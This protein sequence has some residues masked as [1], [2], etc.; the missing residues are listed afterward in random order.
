MV[1]TAGLAFLLVF[2]C[3]PPAYPAGGGA[4]SLPTLQNSSASTA[5]LTGRP[6]AT[7]PEM[8][9]RLPCTARLQSSADP[10]AAVLT[11]NS[12][13]T[14]VRRAIAAHETG[15][16]AKPDR[17]TFLAILLVLLPMERPRFLDYSLLQRPSRIQSVSGDLLP[18]V[19]CT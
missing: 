13:P 3:L 9:K 8:L 16:R 19:N 17:E 12:A 1:R 4:V 5:G 10:K 18:P 15:G 2:A 6:R 11:G 7:M 14:E